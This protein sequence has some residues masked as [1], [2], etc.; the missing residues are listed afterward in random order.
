MILTNSTMSQSA[1]WQARTRSVSRPGR[2]DVREAVALFLERRASRGVVTLGARTALVYGALTRL[3]GAGPPWV[4]KELLLDDP[5]PG[6]GGALKR[7]AYR[8]ALRHCRA[9]VVYSEA[10]RAPA[11]AALGLGLERCV[12]VPFHTRREPAAEPLDG[13]G[14]M[15]A[16]GRSLRD[17][18]TLAEAVRLAGCRVE[19]IAPAV[20]GRALAGAPGVDF[21]GEVPDAEYRLRLERATAVI[22]PLR[23][24]ARSA[25]QAVVLEAMA[26]GKAV[27]C[28][29][30]PG[31][32]D[33][34]RP[35]VTALAYPPGNAEA[36]AARL[37]QLADPAL[38]LRLGRAAQQVARERFTPDRHARAVLELLAGDAPEEART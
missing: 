12:F 5:A 4:A 33:Y 2:S 37:R 25:G 38:R 15:L 1:L 17:Y 8:W 7:A 34:V 19:V 13:D 18:R 29:D 36:L 35:G 10:E 32:R 6:A 11:A 3:L 30:V 26:L 28:A 24:T 14:P 20:E 21:L 22:V 31:L 27:V 9:A 23:A 16:A